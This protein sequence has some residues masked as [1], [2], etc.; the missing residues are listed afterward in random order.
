[1]VNNNTGI[2]F[3]T[4]IDTISKYGDPSVIRIPYTY[5]TSN[6]EL[7]TEGT[8]GNPETSTAYISRK[9]KKFLSDKSGFIESSEIIMLIYPTQTMSRGDHIQWN[10]NEYFVQSVLNRDQ[11]GGN[12]VYKA[13]DL[14][15]IG[16]ITP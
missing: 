8:A 10:G 1:M 3:Q 15:L 7:D 6:V 2:N 5:T 16:P 9:T 13:C 4:I 14:I 12:V 11:P